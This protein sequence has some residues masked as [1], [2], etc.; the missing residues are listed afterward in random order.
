MDEDTRRRIKLL[1][2]QVGDLQQMVRALVSELKMAPGQQINI[3]W[4]MKTLEIA[5]READ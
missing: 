3:A 1:E 5:P 4:M 2:E